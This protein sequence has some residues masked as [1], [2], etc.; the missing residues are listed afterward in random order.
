MGNILIITGGSKG[1]GKAIAQK[2]ALE[3]YK[4]YSLARSITDIENVTQIAVDLSDTKTIKKTFLMLFDELKSQ[5]ISSITLLNNAGR[6]GKIANLENI[7]VEDIA[8]SIRLNTITPLIL[9]SLF[10]KHTKHLMCKKQIINISSGAATTPYE[11]WSV[12]C[13]SK[14]AL[15]MSTKAIA[16][17]QKKLKNGVKCVAIYPGVVD[18]NMQSKIRN[19]SEEDFRSLQRFIDLKE[20]NELYTPEFVAKTIFKIDIEN[21]LE[22]SDIVDLRN[23]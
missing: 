17:E 16:A 13:S 20:N 19:T 15:D 3:N 8:T 14:A 9:S 11:G 23:F 2:Y 7:D 22:S 1:I 4:V 10:I 12:Y 21:Q 6:L 18:T 5:E